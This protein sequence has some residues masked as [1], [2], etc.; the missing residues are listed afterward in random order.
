ML[1]LCHIT[2]ALHSG[3]VEQR[4]ARVIAGL[5][6]A[7]YEL[8]WIGLS[9]RNEALVARAGSDVTVHSVP[10][11]RTR[12]VDYG[13]VFR[14]ARL[15]RSGRVDMVH[16]HNWSTSVYGIVGA[17]LAGVKRV[18]YGMGG[19]ET[20]EGA[21][22][23]QKAAMRVLAPY[24]D[25]LTAVCDFLAREMAVEW[26]VSPLDIDV[27]RSGIDLS[28]FD[29][30]APRAEARRRL[31]VPDDAI[32]VGA[33]TVLRPVKRV[34][35]LIAAAGRA[36]QEDPRI[37]VVLVGNIHDNSADTIRGWAA[38]AGIG[39]RIRIKGRVE[40]PENLL[41]GIDIYVNCSIFEGA[42]NSIMEA[43]AAGLA[44]VGTRVGGTPELARHEETAL[45]VEPRNIDQLAAAISRLAMDRDLR[46]RL[47][48]RARREAHDR[49]GV[50]RMV[51][52]YDALYRRVARE[53]ERKIAS[54][55][56]RAAGGVLS[57]LALVAEERLTG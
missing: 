28:R 22:V 37:H 5:D 17:H 36:A 43:M 47:G 26:G 18:L 51:A 29:A 14:I 38:S 46:L 39:D 45:L 55:S 53:P 23:K 4:V 16:V 57:G 56:V 10:K 52:A 21:N 35:D 13:L 42:S 44:L 40:D 49:F 32:V 33:L 54:R 19:R 41:A 20:V 27:I 31:E 25:R 12:G 15:L 24:V 48:E 9:E 30:A 1:R 2:P 8:S 3:G 50:D 11:G 6:R 7:D 34:D